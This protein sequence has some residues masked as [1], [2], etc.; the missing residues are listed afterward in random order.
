MKHRWDIT[1]ARA[2]SEQRHPTMEYYKRMFESKGKLSLG[3]NDVFSDPVGISLSVLSINKTAAN[4]VRKRVTI[5]TNQ[6]LA[7]SI[8]SATI[9]WL[10]LS[11]KSPLR[12]FVGIICDT[13]IIIIDVICV[14]NSVRYLFLVI[15]RRG[16]SICAT[17]SEI[18]RIFKYTIFTYCF[19]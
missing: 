5:E 18:L 12:V 15:S 1:L 9:S 3:N 10:S 6:R 17:C 8:G 4:I 19:I 13:N 7:I 11:F 2:P 14:F 16:T